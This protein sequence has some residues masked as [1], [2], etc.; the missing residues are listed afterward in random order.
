MLTFTQR[1]Q[2]AAKLCGIH[3]TEPEMETIVLNLN[4]ADKLFQNAARRP[5][6]RKEKTTNLVANQQY[7]QIATDMYRVAEVR[8]KQA[9]NST[10]IVPLEEVRSE[11]EW[12]RLNA[13]PSAGMFP[14]HF[15]IRGNDEI[16][17]FPV[18]ANNITDGLMV[19]YE[20]RIRDMGK[21]D[22]NFTAAVTEN[23]TTITAS[24]NVF[25]PYMVENWYIYNTDGTDGNY[26]KI[27][28][29]ISATKV[30]IE[31]NYLGVT[32]ASAS[33]SMGQVPP[34]PEEYHEASVFYAVFKFFAMRKDTD[35]SAMYRTL[36]EDALRQ[37][38]TRYGNKT[39]SGVVTPGRRRL[40]NITDV[41][42]N[43]TLTEGA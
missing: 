29:Y 33:L 32:N 9:T 15:F 35:S 7:Y 26:Y 18:P 2:Q 1:K 25:Q 10:V 14:T 41:F 37:Y 8:C 3:Y 24:T 22:V 39:V 5:W 38:Q 28:K 27:Q 40:P 43:S 12:N 16:G 6:T 17:I 23:S 4:L 31:N 13:F 19:A 42:A 30:E 20:P 11:H 36:F 34:Y 21:D